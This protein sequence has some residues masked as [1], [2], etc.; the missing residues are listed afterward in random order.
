MKD[1][2][3]KLM[4]DALERAIVELE[5]VEPNDDA[6]F[7]NLT[8][9]VQSPLGENE[10]SSNVVAIAADNGEIQDISRTQEVYYTDDDRKDY[11][12]ENDVLIFSTGSGV[13]LSTTQV[14]PTRK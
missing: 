1:E 13:N 7:V 12:I 9:G 5:V 3:K 2:T 11:V 10:W 6:V 14:H 4:R 8:L